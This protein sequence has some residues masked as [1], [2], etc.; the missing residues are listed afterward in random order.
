VATS[1]TKAAKSAAA[2]LPEFKQY[3]EADG[4]FFF[5]LTGTD[6]AELLQSDG[7]AEGKAA[8]AWV[9]RL[10]TEGSAALAEAPVQLVADRAAVEAALAALVA[11][12][13]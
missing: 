2:R 9:K 11:A 13:E 10:K 7:L 12:Q 1:G 6:G 5:K 8:G 4:R 3:R